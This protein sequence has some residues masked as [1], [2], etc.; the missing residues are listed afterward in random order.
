MKISTAQIRTSESV[1][2]VALSGGVD[3]AVAAG[4]LIQQGYNV[5]GVFMKN[6]SGEEFGIEDQCPWRDDQESAET[7]CRYLKIPFRTYNF[8][9]EYR[10]SIISYF[11]DEYRAGR[12]PNP[13]ILCNQVIKFGSFLDKALEDGAHAIATGH[14]AGIQVNQ[15]GTLDLIKAADPS[16]DQTYFLYRLSQKQLLQSLFPLAR[17]K[18]TEV[19]EIAKKLNLPNAKRKDSQGICFLGK[20]DVSEFLMKE[21]KS[22][23]GDIVDIDTGKQVGTQIGVWYYTLGQR[24]GLQIGGSGEPYYVCRK[25]V[26]EN[27]LYVAK[28]KDNPALYCKQIT[29][30]DIHWIN[31]PPDHTTRMLSCQVRYRQD[32]QPCRFSQNVVTFQKPVWLPAQGQSAVLIDNEIVLGGGIIE[33]IRG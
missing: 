20:I 16:K 14:Y 13:D 19:R 30:S 33:A 26:A 9:K 3:S 15:N 23:R 18:K 4:L 22:R 1:C 11:F 21:I 32:L 6:W 8:E 7:V 27:I 12:T 25:D 17:L 5:T 2:Y 29:L 31:Q 10:R 28:G 24:E